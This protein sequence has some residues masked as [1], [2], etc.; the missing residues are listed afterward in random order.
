MPAFSL[1]SASPAAGGGPG[2]IGGGAA[3]QAA[4]LVAHSAQARTRRRRRDGH[5]VGDA[6]L[7]ACAVGAVAEHAARRL[8][9]RLSGL[10]RV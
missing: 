4:A 8:L 5:A 10:R 3:R 7:A 9:T 6:L 1:C 2:R